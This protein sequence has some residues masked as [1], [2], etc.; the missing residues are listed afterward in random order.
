MEEIGEFYS[1]ARFAAR[2]PATIDFSQ[3]LSNEFSQRYFGRA[4]KEFRCNQL[5][6]WSFQAEDDQHFVKLRQIARAK[7]RKLAL[8]QSQRQTTDRPAFAR[9]ATGSSQQE[10]E[11]STSIAGVDQELPSEPRNSI[12]IFKIPLDGGLYFCRNGAS[13]LPTIQFRTCSSRYSISRGFTLVLV[14]SEFK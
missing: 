11:K 7:R 3:Q 9:F 12:S 13:A 10:L 6:A 2:A 8:H 5:I 1:K 4:A 14:S